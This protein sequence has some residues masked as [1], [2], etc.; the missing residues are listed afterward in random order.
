MQNAKRIGNFIKKVA[1]EKD[2]S[3]KQIAETI[4]CTEREVQQFCNGEEWASFHQLEKIASLLEVT[5]QQLLEGIES[6]NE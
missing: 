1:K 2:I 5:M 3:L 4:S 6:S